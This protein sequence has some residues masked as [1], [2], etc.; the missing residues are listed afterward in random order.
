MKIWP[1]AIPHLMIREIIEDLP[2]ALF[3]A[4]V[5]G[6]FLTM[7]MVWCAVIQ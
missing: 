6:M 5:V 2:A 4:F 3:T 1:P 7:V